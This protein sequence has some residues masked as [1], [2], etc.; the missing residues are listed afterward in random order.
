MFKFF[1]FNNF[2][3]SLC[4]QVQN[5][6]LTDKGELKIADF[7]LAV[8]HKQTTGSLSIPPNYRVGTKRYMAPEVLSETMK[9]D[10]F[11]SYRYADM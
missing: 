9:S 10:D 4:F 1:I 8:T 7:G 3:L 6:L 11:N 2:S 5:L